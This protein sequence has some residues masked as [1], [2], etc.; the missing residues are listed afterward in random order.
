M[1]NDIGIIIFMLIYFCLLGLAIG[2]SSR[3]VAKHLKD[4]D[5]SDK[6]NNK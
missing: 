4:N 2:I 6:T 3:Y 1:I 5:K